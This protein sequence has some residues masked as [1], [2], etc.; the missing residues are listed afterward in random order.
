VEAIIGELGELNHRD[1]SV[2]LVLT[3][4]ISYISY[5]GEVSYHKDMARAP[6]PTQ[7]LAK[8]PSKMQAAA[9][10]T[11]APVPTVILKNG[12]VKTNNAASPSKL[13]TPMAP[14]LKSGPIA[15]HRGTAFVSVAA[16]SSKRS[17]PTK[18]KFH[19]KQQSKQEASPARPAHLIIKK[20][21]S[22]SPTL[23]APVPAPAPTPTL[24]VQKWGE[25]VVAGRLIRH[26]ALATTV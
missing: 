12:A 20:P 15:A 13:A 6:Q 24:V 19:Q 25:V 14:V 8:T 26:Y 7:A 4:L 16:E 1:D 3:E 22:S 2:E 5:L 23:P 17:V 21:W 10:S 11:L 9:A 18:K